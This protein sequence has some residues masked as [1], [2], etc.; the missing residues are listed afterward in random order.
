MIKEVTMYTV[1]CD[2]CGKDNG[3]GGE[4]ACWGDEF[5]ARYDAESNDWN[6]IEG[7]DYCQDCVM[8][9]E[10]ESELVP[11]PDA[12]TDQTAPAQGIE[13]ESPQ[14]EGRGLGTD[15]PVAS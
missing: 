14:P 15:S 5:D 3:E 1:V 12:Q 4:F 9:N 11:K 13:V 2:R 6:E 7:K 10:D 8:W